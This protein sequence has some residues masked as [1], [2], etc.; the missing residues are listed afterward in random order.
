MKIG[1]IGVGV[2]GGAVK[3]GFNAF[4]IP[5]AAYDIAKPELGTL[6]AALASDVIFV[7]LPTP[8][9]NGQQDLSAIIEIFGKASGCQGVLALKSTVL[10]GTTA[11][12]AKQ[13]PGLKIV[14]QPEFL[15]Q[16]RANQDFIE[17]RIA[18][19]GGLE[20][21]AVKSAYGMLRIDTRCLTDPTVTELIKYTHNLGLATQVSFLNDIF[22]VCA[23]VGVNYDE[24]I[25]GALQLGKIAPSHSRVPGPDGKRGYGGMCF[26]K[27]IAAIL[28]W[29]GPGLDTL[30]GVANTNKRVRK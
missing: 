5:V 22:D 13:F 3:N 8:T 15:T 4:N 21:Y 12:L 30:E 18:F 2:V 7:C 24:V 17:Q 29:Y 27:D 9:V 20:S 1:I 16:A 28:G 11:S 26:P 10:P 6:D 23:R 14:H 19:I 25:R